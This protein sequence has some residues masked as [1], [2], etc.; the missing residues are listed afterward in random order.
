MEGERGGGTTVGRQGRQ[1][2]A[3]EG[4]QSDYDEIDPTGVVRL[5]PGVRCFSL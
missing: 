2:E 1:R 4:G 3:L 5:W